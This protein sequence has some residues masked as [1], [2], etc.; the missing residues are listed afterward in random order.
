[1]PLA[2]L[3]TDCQA[4]PPVVGAASVPAAVAQ[5]LPPVR[6]GLAPT[7][8]QP[9]QRVHQPALLTIAPARRVP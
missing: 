8:F 1:M 4:S 2:V 5:R 7:A 6:F 9:V 3:E